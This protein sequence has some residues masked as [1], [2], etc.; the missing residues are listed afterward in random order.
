MGFSLKLAD[1]V[2]VWRIDR[3]IRGFDGKLHGEFSGQAVFSEV[4][5]GLTYVEAGTLLSN[6]T[7][8]QAERRYLWLGAPQ[9]RKIEVRFDDGRAFHEIDL[10][11]PEH[12]PQARH[13]CDPDTYVVTYDFCNWPEWEA[14][15][16]VTGPRK[17][18]V[19]VSRYSRAD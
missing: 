7:R 1:F 10:A 11:T 19:M 8:M 14:R 13:F 18:Y 6:G 9:A 4:S 15:W 3:E 16:R 5:N 17:S 12:E 2:G